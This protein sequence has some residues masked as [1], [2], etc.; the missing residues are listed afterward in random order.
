MIV[1]WEGAHFINQNSI[2]GTLYGHQGWPRVI[3]DNGD[4]NALENCMPET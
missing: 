3:Q 4:R 1:Q 2:P